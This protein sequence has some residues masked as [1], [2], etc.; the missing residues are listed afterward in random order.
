MEEIICKISKVTKRSEDVLFIDIEKNK[1]FEKRD[2]VELKMAARKLGSGQRFYNLIN[3][4]E[5]TLPNKEAREFSSSQNG[6]QFKIADAF[7]VKTLAQRIMANMMIKLNTPPIPTKV[8]S[9]IKDA[10]NWIN[11]LKKQHSVIA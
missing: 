1:S 7:V 3:V 11:K 6:C 9:N 8:F 5:F 2:F 10:E 4:G